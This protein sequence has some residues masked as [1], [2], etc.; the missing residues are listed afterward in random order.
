MRDGAMRD[1]VI[2][3][4]ISDGGRQNDELQLETLQEMAAKRH[5]NVVEIIRVHDSASLLGKAN[6]KGDEFEAAR[7]HL[8]EGARRGTWSVVIARKLSR[9]S[10]RGYRDLDRFLESLE[11]CGCEL[12]TWEET[13]LQDASLGWVRKLL[14]LIESERNAEEMIRHS[15][16]TRRGMAKA[17]AQGKQIGG[18][19][20]GARDKRTTARANRSA[21]VRAA[22]AGPG[23][24]A[25]RAA[26]A[27]RNRARSKAA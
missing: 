10:R 1:G 14:T 13:W 17:K 12:W 25:R 4:R 19:Q 11:G 24:E 9:L 23:G 8:V 15:D 20:L 22:W 7:E 27:E 2:F 16:N 18:R 6:G 5:V 26:L 21:G 3:V